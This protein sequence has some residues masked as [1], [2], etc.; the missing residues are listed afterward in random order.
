MHRATRGL[1][2]RQTVKGKAEATKATSQKVQ[3]T[4]GKARTTT[5]SSVKAK[6]AKNVPELVP[7]YL[8]TPV[9]LYT[10]AYILTPFTRSTGSA[11]VFFGDEQMSDEE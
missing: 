8:L 3:R 6:A 4:P 2:R 7:F 10:P 1:P 5:K 11:N 9:M